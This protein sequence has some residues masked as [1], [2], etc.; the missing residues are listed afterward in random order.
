MFKVIIVEDDPMVAQIN[1]S[2]IEQMP[3]LAVCAVLGN[4]RQALDF[5]REN[6]ADLAILDVYMPEL[7]GIDLL[8]AMRGQGLDTDVIMVTAANDARQ[9]DEMLR[10]GVVDYLVKPFTGARFRE[11]VDKFV[12]KRSALR[13]RNGAAVEQSVIDKL[14]GSAQIAG[15]VLSAAGSEPGSA[16]PQKGL[17]R[18]TLDLILGCMRTSGNLFRS[19]D[20]IAGQAG[21]SKVTVR[22]YLNHLTECGMVES[23][24][25]YDTG[26]RPSVKYRSMLS[27]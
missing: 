13:P 26:G 10:L 8:K 12:F 9:I 24:I 14:T 20:S 25:D 6:G 11:A 23:I 1:R 18:H 19:C 16:L 17:Q 3:D 22:R 5:F 21:L 4:G 7:N 2:Y 15:E 27:G